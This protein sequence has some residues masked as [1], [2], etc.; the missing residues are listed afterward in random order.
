M[1]RFSHA[2]LSLSLFLLSFLGCSRCPQTCEYEPPLACLTFIDRDGSTIT[3]Q[4][5]ER[6]KQY[7][8]VD[9]LGPQPYDKVMRIYKRD[10]DG[11][12]CTF[13][14][15][16]HPNGQLKQYLEVLNG[17]AY[18]A[19]REWHENGTLKLETYV[20]AGT[21]D[22][23][24]EAQKNWQFDGKSHI[25][26]DCGNV[27]ACFN[28]CKG[29]LEGESFHY[30]P[31]GQIKLHTFYV[32]NLKQ[33]KEEMFFA[34]GQPM[35]CANWSE[36]ELRG[37]AMRYWPSGSLASEENHDGPYLLDAEYFTPEGTLLSSITDGKGTRAIWNKHFLKELQEFSDGVQD[38][39]VKVFADRGY[40]KNVYHVKNGM[41]HGDDYRYYPPPTGNPGKDPDTL[42]PQLLITWHEGQIHGFTKTWYPDGT[43]ESQ[44]EMSSNHKSGIATAW[45][46]DG[47][48][49]LMEEY[50]KDKL[51]RGE[52]F[53]KG[54]RRAETRIVD[55]DGI[56][57]LYDSHGQ[58]LRKV[59]Y[60][61]GNVLD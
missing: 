45:Y 10:S 24:P 22:I 29:A 3:I 26:D 38:G 40:V 51:I 27:L 2:L 59:N 9:F 30:Y 37:K 47:N 52:Y 44:R 18:G 43:L 35:A 17:G 48:I 28:Y 14:T 32:R 31:D 57:S 39:K 12:I 50:N 23:T 19:Y 20:M 34:D 15:S 1:I 55:G 33:G 56:A 8:N 11:N 21:A 41:K 53:K 61:H 42:Q 60:Y 25:W 58:L 49:M 36:G 46:N 54:N 13:I 4:A 7:E 6:L 5:N 16:Y